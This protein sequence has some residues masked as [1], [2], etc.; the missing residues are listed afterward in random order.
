MNHWVPL[1]W[2]AKDQGCLRAFWKLCGGIGG[3]IHG[4]QKWIIEKEKEEWWSQP[5][6]TWVNCAGCFA[7]MLLLMPCCT[8][9]FGRKVGRA[10][11]KSCILQWQNHM[12]SAGFDDESSFFFSFKW[13]VCQGISYKWNFL[14]LESFIFLLAV[15]RSLILH[16]FVNA[17]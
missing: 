9:N 10:L 17:S 1:H 2:R 13:K 15:K 11:P 7:V 8:G 6:V 3:V 14:G 16:V 4:D 12:V 5:D